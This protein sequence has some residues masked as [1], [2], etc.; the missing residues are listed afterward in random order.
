MKLICLSTSLTLKESHLCRRKRFLIITQFSAS[1]WV[2]PSPSIAFL[3]CGL[4]FDQF[5]LFA[6]NKNSL[7]KQH[8]SM[9]ST[10][11]F[12]VPF[13][14]FVSGSELKCIS[15]IAV[16]VVVGGV[17]MRVGNLFAQCMLKASVVKIAET[18][19]LFR[20]L[21]ILS[22]IQSCFEKLSAA[23]G[24]RFAVRQCECI[25]EIRRISCTRNGA[26]IF[27]SFPIFRLD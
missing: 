10:L 3:C 16:V 27:L 20:C 6:P 15:Y 4:E 11:P 17:C 25:G 18:L 12:P 14:G 24:R 26:A 8:L 2:R 9:S 21:S 22:I 19:S 1:F 5:C 23:F 13:P 7:A